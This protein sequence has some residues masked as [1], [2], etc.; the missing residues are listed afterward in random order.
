MRAIQAPIRARVAG[1]NQLPP[2]N[3]PA[4]QIREGWMEMILLNIR[5]AICPRQAT[6]AAL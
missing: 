6:N 5:P 3:A 1:L 4:T 2:Q